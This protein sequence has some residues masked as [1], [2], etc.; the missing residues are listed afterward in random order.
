[1]KILLIGGAGLIGSKL[2][3]MLHGGGHETLV[4]DSFVGSSR[5]HSNIKGQT[6]TGNAGSFS[7]LNNVFSWFQPRVVFHLADDVLDKDSNYF[8]ELEADTCVNVATNILRCIRQY[9]VEFVFFGSSCEV[10][11]GGSKRPVKETSD[12]VNVSYTGATKNYVE[13]LFKLNSD[14]YGYKFTSLR[15]FGVCGNRYFLNPKHDVISFFVDSLV[16]FLMFSNFYN[17]ADFYVVKIFD[18]LL[19]LIFG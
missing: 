6:I 16:F 2:E 5:E 18:H 1:M 3:N 9:S 10:Y 17:S 7:V 13:S 11:K 15:Y 8:F 4:L 12:T 14:F 19:F